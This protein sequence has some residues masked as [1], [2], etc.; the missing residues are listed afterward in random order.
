[1]KGQNTA[2][3][4][5]WDCQKAVGA[6]SWSKNLTPVEGWE[7]EE[8]PYMMYHGGGCDIHRTWHVMGCPEFVRDEP[9]VN[10][11]LILTK[12]ENEEFVKGRY[13]KKFYADYHKQE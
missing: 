2:Q 12:E 1:M 13:F 4:I 5:C 11:G 6:C 10:T 9:R 3:N 8:V 7:A